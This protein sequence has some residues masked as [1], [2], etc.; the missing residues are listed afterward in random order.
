MKYNAEYS[1]QAIK[2]IKRADHEM[3]KRLKRRMDELCENPY[4]G[5]RL[6]NTNNYRDRVGSYRIVYDINRSE[7][8]I[9]VH[10]IEP[11][12]KVYKHHDARL[13]DGRGGRA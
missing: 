10:Q 1:P 8:Q 9:T 2:G 7:H 6:V 3:R 11:R 5:K 4:Q 12:S 13:R